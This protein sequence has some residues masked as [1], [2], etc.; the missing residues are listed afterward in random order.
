MFPFYSTLI[1]F[2]LWRKIANAEIVDGELWNR[3]GQFVK[4]WRGWKAGLRRTVQKNQQDTAARIWSSLSVSVLH[5]DTRA[6]TN[7][8]LV[9]AWKLISGWWPD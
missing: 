2:M 7:R 3:M 5:K 9:A 1:V 6:Q 4:N 8:L